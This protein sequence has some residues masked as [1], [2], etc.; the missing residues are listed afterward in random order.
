MTEPRR[1]L[2]G[3]GSDEERRLLAAGAA[4]EPPAHGQKRLALALG[5]GAAPWHPAEAA[6]ASSRAALP[7][8]VGTKL[9]LKALLALG[10][11]AALAVT[12]VRFSPGAQRS[13]PESV[14]PPVAR[15]TKQAEGPTPVT[16]TPRAGGVE[17]GSSAPAQG[18]EMLMQG[19]I[20]DEVA[21]LDAAQRALSAHDPELSLAR[22]D[23][24]AR[25][26]PHGSLLPE[27]LRLRIAAELARGDARRARE[28]SRDFLRV[29]P[30]SP[31]AAALRPIAESA[32][33]TPRQRDDEAPS[34]TP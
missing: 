1:L 34:R 20:A 31:H 14:A 7:K 8:L 17:V 4:E 33:E 9:A 25:R 12:L 19:A 13:A 18:K 27:A 22:L 30:D 16:Q 11:G 5:L 23:G 21:R 6:K 26:Y 28:L 32:R 3:E 15:S 10:A 2:H 29:Y 24:Y